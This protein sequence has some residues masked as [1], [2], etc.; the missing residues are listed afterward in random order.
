MVLVSTIQHYIFFSNTIR[1]HSLQY[2]IGYFPEDLFVEEVPLKLIEDFQK[3]LKEL[4]AV[5]EE[6]NKKLELPYIYLSPENVENS[7]S[8]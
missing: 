7:V 3:D 6:R 1:T 4:S 8:I 2:L 5:I